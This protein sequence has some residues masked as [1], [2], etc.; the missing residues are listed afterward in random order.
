MAMSFHN[1]FDLPL[2]IARP[3]NTY[4]PRQSARAVIP[5]IISQIAD[6]K[7]EIMLGDISPTRDFNFVKD[8]CRAFIEL[9]LCNEATGEVVNIGS[10]QEITIKDTFEKIGKIMKKEIKF[11]K[12]DKRIR[13]EKSEV[14][15]LL[16][17]NTKINKL[18][19]FTPEYDLEE[20]LKETVD[21]FINPVNL[22]K[23]KS[24]IY[25]V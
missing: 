24:D 23:Y 3:F 2:V 7:N 11:V 12:D 4:G 5:S 16:C 20:G 15:R 19:G 8:T 21:W 14:H 1:S 9:A 13:P 10:G 18:T 17:D 22:S 6:G 25:N